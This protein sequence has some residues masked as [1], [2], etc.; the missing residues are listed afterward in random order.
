[1]ELIR[2]DGKK[3]TLIVL[4]VM[5]T[6]GKN[7]HGIRRSHLFPQNAPPLSSDA[8]LETGRRGR[9]HSMCMSGATSPPVFRGEHV[10]W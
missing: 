6:V 10:V 5:F 2:D 9:L 4:S 7:F 1:M 3:M 8:R